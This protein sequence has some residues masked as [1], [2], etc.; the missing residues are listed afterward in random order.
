MAYL[1]SACGPGVT[2]D[3]GATVIVEDGNGC[4][5]TAR[6]HSATGRLLRARGPFGFMAQSDRG[7]ARIGPKFETTQ[8]PRAIW[9][10]KAD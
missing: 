1:F 2:C 4:N 6:R 3:M 7:E 10:I 5:R 9:L 8:K